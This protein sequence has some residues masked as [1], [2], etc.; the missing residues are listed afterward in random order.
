MLFNTRENRGDSVFL[1]MLLRTL[2]WYPTE[3]DRIA[4]FPTEIK[5]LPM[6]LLTNLRKYRADSFASAEP[7]AGQG[8]KLRRNW[9]RNVFIRSLPP[10]FLVRPLEFAH[11]FPSVL[12][13]GFRARRGTQL[14]SMPRSQAIPEKQILRFAQDFAC[15]LPLGFAWFPRHAGTCGTQAKRLKLSKILA[16]TQWISVARGRSARF[17]APNISIAVG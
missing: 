16:E 8:V 6:D 17:T 12:R 5:C 10:P 4:F 9:R 15:G 3:S 2:S 1:S 11:T 13:V 14:R 7:V